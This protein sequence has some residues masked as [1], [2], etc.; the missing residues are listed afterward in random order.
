MDVAST[1]VQASTMGITA[2]L[3]PFLSLPGPIIAGI[4]VSEF[5][6]EASF[7]YAGAVT[8]LAALLLAIIHVPRSSIPTPR[9]SE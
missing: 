3:G 7:L 5:G 9:S 1:R 4:L 8:L 2:L 6:T